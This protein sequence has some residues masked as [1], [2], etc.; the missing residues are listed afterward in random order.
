MPCKRYVQ[1]IAGS[2]IDLIGFFLLGFSGDYTAGET[3]LPIPNRAVKPRR[4]DGT[5]WVTV[6]ESRSLPGVFDE[7][8]I[9]FTRAGLSSYMEPP[10]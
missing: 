8:P 3:P 7:S 9:L 5:I 2:N 1:C 6:W 4:A 10:D